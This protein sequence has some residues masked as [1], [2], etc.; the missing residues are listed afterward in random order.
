MGIKPYA[1]SKRSLADLRVY[2]TDSLNNFLLLREVSGLVNSPANVM[3]TNFHAAILTRVA[4][5]Q[6][7]RD[8]SPI[9]SALLS[10]SHTI[11]R[12][13]AREKCRAARFV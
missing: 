6:G 5:I 9:S 11:S 8:T 3:S 12:R 1:A 2:R 10:S 7:V 4:K 13:S